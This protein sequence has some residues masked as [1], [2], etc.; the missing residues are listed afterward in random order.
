MR[1][2]TTRY[3][4][5]RARDLQFLEKRVRQFMSA[6]VASCTRMAQVSFLLYCQVLLA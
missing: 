1:R 5:R 2:R 6:R 4:T 3:F